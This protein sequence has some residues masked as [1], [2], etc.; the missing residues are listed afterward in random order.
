MLLAK[1]ITRTILTKLENCP[2]FS[3]IMDTTPDVSGSE[4]LTL[5]LRFFDFETM[6]ICEHFMGF[7]EIKRQDAST[8]LQAFIT[9][10]EDNDIP[11]SKLRGQGYDNG[12]NMSGTS[13]GK[14][15]Y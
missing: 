1:K 7:I 8:L 6:R 9:F 14:S 15:A 10:L 3:V 13:S 11:L 2:F 12:A 5:V 4:Q